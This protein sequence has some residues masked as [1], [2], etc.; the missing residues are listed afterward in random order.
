L[1]S[2][3]IYFNSV[4]GN[5][6]LISANLDDLS[7]GLILGKVD[8]VNGKYFFSFKIESSSLMFT[9]YSNSGY[10]KISYDISSKNECRKSDLG[11]FIQNIVPE[12]IHNNK[13]NMNKRLAHYVFS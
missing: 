4:A 12:E 7:E 3:K 2:D 8:S 9:L 13:K 5:S 1:A 10:Y 11:I 6:L